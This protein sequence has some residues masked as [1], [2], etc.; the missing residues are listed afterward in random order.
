MLFVRWQ[1]LGEESARAE[2]VECFLPLAREFARRFARDRDSFEDLFQVASLALLKAIDRFDV[3]RGCAFSSFA[4]PTITGELKKHARDFG[5]HVHVPRGIRERVVRLKRAAEALAPELGRSPTPGELAEACGLTTSE[6]LEAM[7]AE[8]AARPASLELA[9]SDD[10]GPPAPARRTVQEEPGYELV[11]Y[12]DVIARR[13]RCCSERER[14]MLRLRLV[15][16]LPQR[17]IGR[18]V[19]VSQ[20]QVS[21]VL[22]QLLGD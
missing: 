6:V 15:E 17:E 8:A 3:E 9:P 14:L 10:G 22:R 1:R 11:E 21:R 16:E 2:L 7:E 4:V 5:W 20:M 19:G 13:L 18:R 12:R